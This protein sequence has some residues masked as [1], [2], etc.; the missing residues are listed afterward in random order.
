M[1]FLA[2]NRMKNNE[3]TGSRKNLRNSNQN[4]RIL[5]FKGIWGDCDRLYTKYGV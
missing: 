5:E 4:Y 3:I 2:G 1:S